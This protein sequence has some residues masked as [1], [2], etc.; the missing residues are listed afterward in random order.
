MLGSEDCWFFV[1][2]QDTVTQVNEHE[3]W[4]RTLH[5]DKLN[6]NALV[7]CYGGVHRCFQAHKHLGLVSF[8]LVEVFA[9][10]CHLAGG[11]CACNWMEPPFCKEF[12]NAN[13]SGGIGD[14]CLSLTPLGD[15]KAWLGKQTNAFP[16][17]ECLW[18]V[19]QF[20]FN[21]S[22]AQFP[23]T[24]LSEWFQ[25]DKTQTLVFQKAVFPFTEGVFVNNSTNWLPGL[26]SV[27]VRCPWVRRS[28]PQGCIELAVSKCDNHSNIHMDF[29][30]VGIDSLFEVGSLLRPWQLK[31]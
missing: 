1:I 4:Y 12:C 27:P 31:S 8:S 15:L 9:T 7:R 17:L 18:H 6:Y 21:R 23:P 5:P 30:L 10:R 11:H 26:E 25:D 29:A 3:V 22:L 20:K 14:A 13:L 16:F 19:R 24:L 28:W 2:W